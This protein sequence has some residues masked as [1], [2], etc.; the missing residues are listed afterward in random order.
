MTPQSK[1]AP[2]GIRHGKASADFAEVE[3]ARDM[4]ESGKYPKEIARELDRPIDTVRDWIY[5]R[6]RCYC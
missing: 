5:Y 4:H 1:G 3:R 2:Y 6:T